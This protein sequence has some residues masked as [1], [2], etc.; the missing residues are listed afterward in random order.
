MVNRDILLRDDESPGGITENFEDLE[1][2]APGSPK[3]SSDRITE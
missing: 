3:S 1:N 2:I